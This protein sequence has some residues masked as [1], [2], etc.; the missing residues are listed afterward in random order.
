MKNLLKSRDAGPLKKPAARPAQ[1][2]K[3]AKTSRQTAFRKLA[4]LYSRMQTAY[5]GHAARIGLTCSDCPRNCCYSHFQH[6]TYVEWAYLWA[7]MKELDEDTRR[8]YLQ[9]AHENVRQVQLAQAAGQQPHVMCPVNDDGRC[10]LYV[11]RLMI[12]RLFGVPNRLVMPGGRQAD[13]PGCWR[14]KELAAPEAALPPLDRTEMYR[15]LA[16]LEAAFLG[17]KL[18]KL[19]KVDL[20]LAQMLVAGPP[21]L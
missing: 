19:P 14:T 11:H 18:G 9:R 2:A 8:R 17:K 6:H 3:P 16:G 7:G 21:S 15:D 20:T 5:D 12:C 10:G 13:F 1:Q 4:A